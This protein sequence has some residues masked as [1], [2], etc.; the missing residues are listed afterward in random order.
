MMQD[1]EGCYTTHMA[2]ALSHDVQFP[3]RCI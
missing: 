1:G 2:N 3:W